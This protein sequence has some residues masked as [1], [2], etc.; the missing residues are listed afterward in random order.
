MASLPALPTFGGLR[1]HP[2]HDEA[3]T[4]AKLAAGIDA[5]LSLARRLRDEDVARRSTSVAPPSTAIRG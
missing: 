4:A 1:R 5:K 3:A 2:Q